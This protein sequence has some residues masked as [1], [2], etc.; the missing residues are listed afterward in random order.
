[1]S[2]T[3]GPASTSAA[4]G[5]HPPSDTRR[6][7]IEHGRGAS[8]PRPSSGVRTLVGSIRTAGGPTASR[9]RSLFATPG[10]RAASTGGRGPSL[11]VGSLCLAAGRRNP[12]DAA[13]SR[14]E[15]VGWPRSMTIEA[16]HSRRRS[17]TR[18]AGARGRC[19][20]PPTC[21]RRTAPLDKMFAT[22]DHGLQ[23]TKVPP[24]TIALHVTCTA[25]I[26]AITTFGDVP[27]TGG[28]PGAG[29]LQL[30]ELT[31]G[32]R[33]AT[34]RHHRGRPPTTLGSP[35]PSVLVPA[36]R[37]SGRS[38]T[39]RR[40]WGR[41]DRRPPS[42]LGSHAQTR[43][44]DRPGTPARGRRGRRA[45]GPSRPDKDRHPGVRRRWSAVSGHDPT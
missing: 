30:G 15:A 24:A 7:L 14:G 29:S 13:R 36:D 43:P 28:H 26:V 19:P 39:R 35:D 22:D 27:P 31:R 1:V 6:T 5:F 20:R 17:S 40:P 4:I 42:S 25:G 9:E 2:Q 34:H 41:A 33:P 45:V 18:R 8:R 32:C 12:S 10:R 38:S 16:R 23:G 3:S 44:L 21:P 37:G 11:S